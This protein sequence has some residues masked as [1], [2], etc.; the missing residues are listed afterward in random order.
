[1]YRKEG[2]IP[3]LEISENARRKNTGPQ[4]IAYIQGFGVEAYTPS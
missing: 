4:D 3:F 2:A 1:M